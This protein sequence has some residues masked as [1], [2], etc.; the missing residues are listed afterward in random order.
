[1]TLRTVQ[2]CVLL[3]ENRNWEV[4]NSHHGWWVRSSIN[5]NGQALMLLFGYL[6]VGPGKNHRKKYS[7]TTA[8]ACRTTNRLAAE[9]KASVVLVFRKVTEG[10]LFEV[11]VCVCDW[12]V[13]QCQA[14]FSDSA[15]CMQESD[16]AVFL[17]TREE[18][19]TGPAAQGQ[20]K[21]RQA[22]STER[23]L[24]WYQNQQMNISVWK[25]IMHAV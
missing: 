19:A 11:C 18:K 13:I 12:S 14:V 16:G 24:A 9:Y 7:A 3:L 15:S 22:G 17:P 21:P 8:G 2:I 20:Y 23:Q 4:F 6:S 10:V 25:R 1:L 5:G